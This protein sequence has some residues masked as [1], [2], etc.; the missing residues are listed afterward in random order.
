MGQN[1][2][3]YHNSRW[4]IIILFWKYFVDIRSEV[5]LILVWEYINAKSFAVR[6]RK[7]SIPTEL[8]ADLAEGA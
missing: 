7:I 3:E 5:W 8:L 6:K 2:T 4:N 1:A